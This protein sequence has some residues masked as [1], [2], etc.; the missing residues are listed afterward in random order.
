MTSNR[1]GYEYV[2][3]GK[4]KWYEW[5]SNKLTL[6]W[7]EFSRVLDSMLKVEKSGRREK[8]P[9]HPDVVLK[10]KIQVRNQT[11]NKGVGIIFRIFKLK[12]NWRVNK[13]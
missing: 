11:E 6:I 12:A 3:D 7:Y 2:C 9:L 10:E 4:I 1:N 5:N 8:M 13:I